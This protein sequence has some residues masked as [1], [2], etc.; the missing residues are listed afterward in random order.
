MVLSILVLSIA[1]FTISKDLTNRL[2]LE[3]SENY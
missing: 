1:V 2:L 3:I